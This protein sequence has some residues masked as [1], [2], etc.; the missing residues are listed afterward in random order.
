MAGQPSYQYDDDHR[1]HWRLCWFNQWAVIKVLRV[2]LLYKQGSREVQR[3]IHPKGSI[4]I[5]IR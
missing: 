1:C 3:L 2:L 5:K 4:S